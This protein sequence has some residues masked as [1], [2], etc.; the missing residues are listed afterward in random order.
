MYRRSQRWMLIINNRFLSLYD[1]NFLLVIEKIFSVNSKIC[2]YDC[3]PNWRLNEFL[4]S[5]VK[6]WPVKKKEKSR[7]KEEEDSNNEE[8]HE[9]TRF[10]KTWLSSAWLSLASS[11]LSWES[12]DREL[13][14]WI[15][16]PSKGKTV[17]RP[18][19]E[20]KVLRVF[21]SG[22][23]VPRNQGWLNFWETRLVTVRKSLHRS[24]WTELTCQGILLP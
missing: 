20:G 15:Y 17:A 1:Y 10:P 12:L 2:L 24:C 4:L 18:E 16:S 14:S 13:A 7:E 5:N 19:R 22:R 6:I 23:W 8:N 21:S 3:E 11:I 9:E